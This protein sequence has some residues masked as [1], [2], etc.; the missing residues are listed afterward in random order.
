MT[1]LAWDMA[2][3]IARVLRFERRGDCLLGYSM[4]YGYDHSLSAWCTR[5]VSMHSSMNRASRSCSS[6]T[7]ASVSDSYL[8]VFWSTSLLRL[9]QRLLDHVLELLERQRAGEGTADR[10]RSWACPHRVADL[11]PYRP[12]RAQGSFIVD[13]GRK[14]SCIQPRL[15]PE[16]DQLVLVECAPR[17][18]PAGCYRACRGIPK[19]CPDRRR[20]RWPRRPTA[21]RGRGRRS[22]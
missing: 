19:T 14:R 2:A 3:E 13:A 20:T 1:T 5:A 7:T 4:S 21:I 15:F 22:A 8:L 18:R 10:R 17:S 6:L 12:A 9:G 16:C 11:P